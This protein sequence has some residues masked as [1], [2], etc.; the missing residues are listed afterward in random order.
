M[1]KETC[2]FGIFLILFSFCSNKKSNPNISKESLEISFI[3]KGFKSPMTI[4]CAV[5]NSNEF[6]KSKHFKSINE[7]ETIDEFERLFSKLSINK[8]Q[9]DI[10]TRIQVVYS[11]DKQKDTICMG[12]NF[13]ICVNGVVMNDYKEFHNYVKEII[14]YENTIR[15]PITGKMIPKD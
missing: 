14:D 2:F 5:L 11:H 1:K 4:S 10:D 12:E 8:E 15:H 3:Q 7:N 6:V 9:G 13:N